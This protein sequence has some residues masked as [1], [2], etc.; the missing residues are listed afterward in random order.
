MVGWYRA[1][2][3]ALVESPGSDGRIRAVLDAATAAERRAAAGRL[4][5]A[6]IEVQAGGGGAGRTHEEDESDGRKEHPRDGRRGRGRQS[7]VRQVW[8][9]PSRSR[10]QPCRLTTKSGDSSDR[11][12]TH[13]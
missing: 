6:P 3:I 4:T 9:G 8:H 10:T 2:L 13:R 7:A 11:D 5:D 1:E 12:P